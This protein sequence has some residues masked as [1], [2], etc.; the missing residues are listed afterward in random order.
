MSILKVLSCEARTSD[1]CVGGVKTQ[2]LEFGV[3]FG[4]P[5]WSLVFRAWGF[6]LCLEDRGTILF[7]ATLYCERKFSG[8]EPSTKEIL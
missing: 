1:F 7:F 3:Q 5:V 8:Q 4:G 6:G 2:G